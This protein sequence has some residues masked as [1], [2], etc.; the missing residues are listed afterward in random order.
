MEPLALGEAA[1]TRKPGRLC[2]SFPHSYCYYYYASLLDVLWALVEAGTARDAL[3][4]GDL[5]TP[6][7]NRTP[8]GRRQQPGGPN[9]KS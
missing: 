9:G 1:P 7:S 6:L 8:S 2:F 3:L 5:D 4:D